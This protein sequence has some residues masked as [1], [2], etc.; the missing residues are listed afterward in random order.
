MSAGRLELAFLEML[1]I[2]FRR[3]LVRQL[4]ASLLLRAAAFGMRRDGRRRAKLSSLKCKIKVR[5]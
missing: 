2:L 3:E 4:C 1:R 5:A